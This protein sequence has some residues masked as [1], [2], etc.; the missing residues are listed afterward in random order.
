IGG[1]LDAAPDAA[2]HVHLVAAGDALALRQRLLVGVLAHLL[3]LAFR[4]EHEVVAAGVR[5]GLAAAEGEEREDQR[6]VAT[7]HARK[8]ISKARRFPDQQDGGAEVARDAPAATV[9]E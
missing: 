2:D 7:V 8:I 9:G 3:L 1:A 5:N 4:D 6:E